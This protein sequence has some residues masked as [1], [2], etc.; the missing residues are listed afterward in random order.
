MLDRLSYAMDYVDQDFWILPC[1]KGEKHAA[2][3]WKH[4]E[5]RPMTAQERHAGW[6]NRSDR[7]IALI[8]GRRAG[9][10]VLNSNT[11]NGHDGPGTL[12]RLGWDRIVPPT[13][14][15]ATPS[16]G[17]AYCFKLPDADLCP[18]PFNTYVHPPGFPGLG[19]R[20]GDDHYGVPGVIRGKFSVRKIATTS[21]SAVR[22]DSICK[23]KAF[24]SL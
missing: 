18:F 6:P 23:N 20:G 13:P 17:L 9:L 1:K 4:L 22:H 14:T 10:L 3:K 15:I 5:R 8:C 7:N 19:F 11:K 16:G 24:C 2:I 12:R 21:P